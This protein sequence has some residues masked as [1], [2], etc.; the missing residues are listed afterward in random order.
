[1][2]EL[3][4]E[5]IEQVAGGWVRV[6]ITA[7]SFLAGHVGGKLIDAFDRSI[8]SPGTTWESSPF[9]DAVAAGNMSA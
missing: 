1:M 3:T 6:V 8:S 5:E 7:G 9:L 4:Q 2:R